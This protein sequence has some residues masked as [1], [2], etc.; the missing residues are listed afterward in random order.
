MSFPTVSGGDQRLCRYCAQRIGDSGR[1]RRRHQFEPENRLSPVRVGGA[2]TGLIV[3][4]D[5]G[6]PRVRR[7]ASN[8]ER[9]DGRG[10]SEV[11]VDTGV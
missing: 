3:D 2:D 8:V 5:L 10:P 6:A 4:G 11:G 1:E 9:G 7:A